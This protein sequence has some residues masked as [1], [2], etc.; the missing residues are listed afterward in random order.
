MIK[1]LRLTA[2]LLASTAMFRPFEGKAGWKLND[3]G[4]AVLLKDGNPIYVQTDGTEAVIAS[5]TISQRNLEAKTN[6]ERAEKAERERD[7]LKTKIGDLDPV[8]AREALETVSKLDK[9][10]LI[11]A[12]EVDKVRE[13]MRSEFQ[14]LID[15]ANKERDDARGETASVRIENAFTGSKF[16]TD[17]LA[18]PRDMVQAT[19]GKNFKVEDG[20]IAAYGAD[21]NRIMS[22]AKIGD[23]ADFEEA[24]SLMVESYPQRD[25][26]M[27]GGNQGGSGSQGGGGGGQAGKKRYTRTELEGMPP[28]QQRDI[29]LAAGKGEAEIVD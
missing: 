13:S 27:K 29:S 6:R 26:I 24:M 9:K 15:T 19:F 25:M 12:G 2:A 22:K 7:E 1:T 8:K 3:A 14:T 21:G 5:D 16:I 4:D 18:I 23:F 10:T 20:K 28:A 17:K 11:D